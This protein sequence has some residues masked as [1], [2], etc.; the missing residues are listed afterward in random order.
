MSRMLAYAGRNPNRVSRFLVS[1]FDNITDVE[2]PFGWGMGYEHDSQILLRKSPK[3]SNT[4][5]NLA[6]ACSDLRTRTFIAHVAPTPCR[7]PTD[8][9]PFRWRHW[10]FAMQGE[11][12]LSRPQLRAL[13]TQIPDFLRRN[14]QGQTAEELVFHLF[15][16]RLH[17]QKV[18]LQQVPSQVRETLLVLASVLR[19]VEGIL[20]QPLAISTVLTDSRSLFAAQAGRPLWKH[21]HLEEVPA[22]LDRPRRIEEWGQWTAL[23]SDSVAEPDDSWTSLVSRSLC[24]I[25]AEGQ[26]QEMSLDEPA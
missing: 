23:L 6:R 10:L 22:R 15:L 12:A 4:A 24:A 17:T 9:Q 19:D 8:V 25:D 18:P 2:A 20:E 26:Q 21:Y 7:L 13:R 5:L 3:S 1:K 16:T 11:L 14:V